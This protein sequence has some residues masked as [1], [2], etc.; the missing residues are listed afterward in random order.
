MAAAR[1]SGVGVEGGR[2]EVRDKVRVECSLGRRNG[3][4]PGS[5]VTTPGDGPKGTEAR[6]G[7]TRDASVVTA[8]E[9][10][11]GVAH[12]FIEDG[13]GGRGIVGAVRVVA[14]EEQHPGSCS[15]GWIARGGRGPW[16][17]TSGAIESL[18][19]WM[20]RIGDHQKR[21]R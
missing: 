21:A 6:H 2:R 15:R 18:A 19:C 11:R 17:S 5:K 9:E 20:I 8:M 7:E 3:E 16:T 13:G 10:G 4:D 1:R 12:Q 14:G